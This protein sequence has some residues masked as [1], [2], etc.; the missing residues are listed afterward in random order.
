MVTSQSSGSSYMRGVRSGEEHVAAKTADGDAVSKIRR[1][2]GMPNAPAHA[3]GPNLALDKKQVAD[4]RV[5]ALSKH[6]TSAAG[7]SGVVCAVP[8]QVLEA[9]VVAA[10]AVAVAVTATAA[11]AGARHDPGSAI[12]S[13]TDT[14]TDTS[15]ARA[16]NV[17]ARGHGAAHS[18]ARKRGVDVRVNTR[19]DAA[20]VGEAC[21]DNGHDDPQLHTVQSSKLGPEQQATS[22]KGHTRGAE[23]ASPKYGVGVDKG[24]PPVGSPLSVSCVCVCVCVCVCECVVP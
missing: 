10:T 6:V 15:V 16:G 21:A 8:L 3:A 17:H 19:E 24:T 9:Q 4:T 18:L 20:V 22:A 14:D 5:D 7:G 1:R 23:H 13:E 12:C 11:G 2:L